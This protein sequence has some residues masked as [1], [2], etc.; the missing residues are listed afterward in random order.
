VYSEDGKSVFVCEMQTMKQKNLPKRIRYYQ[1]MIDLN[2]VE[3]GADY[4]ELKNSY[5]I[6]ICPF[7]AF[8]GKLHK[9][10]FENR[11]VENPG[12]AL[13]DETT[14]IFLCAEGSEKDVSQ[15]MADFLNYVAG[16]KN[17]N[18]FVKALDGEVEKAKAHEEW[19]QE[20]MTLLV[21]EQ[22][23]IRQGKEEGLTKGREE[24]IRNMIR[25]GVQKEV[26]LRD[27]SMEEYE[28]AEE[29]LAA[30]TINT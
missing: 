6:F 20:Y 15:D 24:A 22:D 19:R 8:D 29:S 14:K 30:Q 18:P 27:Y 1:A 7:N 16:I 28:K 13:G 2:L 11:C 3:R 21:R 17:D 26:I 9:Y 10:T 12:L 25:Y 4:T 23:L 5:V